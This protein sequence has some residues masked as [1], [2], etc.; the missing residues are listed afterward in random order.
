[1]ERHNISIVVMTGMLAIGTLLCVLNTTYLLALPNFFEQRYLSTR[2]SEI[3]WRTTTTLKLIPPGWADS[4]A[5]FNL[6]D[7]FGHPN[8][9]PDWGSISLTRI[10]LREQ[11]QDVDK[12]KIVL[13]DA[14]SA[15]PVLEKNEIDL[16]QMRYSGLV[17]DFKDQE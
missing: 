15:G 12:I 5:P 6:Y 10:L 14:T 17:P 9:Y 3:D 8:T 7:E 1:V 16:R 4:I 13:E 11:K 2:L